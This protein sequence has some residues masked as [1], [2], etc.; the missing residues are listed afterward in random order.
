MHAK[1]N[2]LF[3]VTSCDLW[4]WCML[5]WNCRWMMVAAWSVT[6]QST[7]SS[8]LWKNSHEYTETGV[9][10]LLLCCVSETAW[11]VYQIV[12]GQTMHGR[13]SCEPVNLWA[14][15]FAAICY[16]MKHSLLLQCIADILSQLMSDVI[17]YANFLV[18]DWYDIVVWLST[19]LHCCVLSLNDTMLMLNKWIGSPLLGTWVYNFHPPTPTLS[20]RLPT[21]KFTQIFQQ[22]QYNQISQKQL[23][24]VLN[25]Q[26]GQLWRPSVNTLTA[27]L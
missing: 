24:F 19:H 20:P 21:S 8:R 15:Q 13:W 5:V 14:G 27:A 16:D 18:N 12:C 3:C 7:I 26:L 23:G 1:S 4:Q 2:A 22:M 10:T 25:I 17:N 6:Q 9:L 11:F